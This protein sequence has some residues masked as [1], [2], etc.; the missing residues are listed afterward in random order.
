MDRQHIPGL[1]LAVLTNGVLAKAQGYGWAD[2]EAKLPVTTNTLFQIQSVTKIFTATAIMLLA[3][4]GKIDIEKRIATYLSNL[5]ASWSNVT[6]RHLL[7]HTS[8]IKDFINEPTVN[9]TNDVTPDEIVKSLADLPLNF[10]TGEQYRYSNTGYQ[11]LGMMIHQITGMPWHEFVRQ[12]VLVPAG[13]SA[14]RV[15][16]VDIQCSDLARGYRWEK[17]Q[18][19]PGYPVAMSILS[20]PGGGL[21]SSAVDLAAWDKALYGEAVVKRSLLER[22]WTPARLNSGAT[23]E[24]GLGW[25]VQEHLGRRFVGHGGAHMTGFKAS[26]THFVEEKVTVI[27]LCN[28]RGANPANVAL[29]VADHYIPGL[30]LSSMQ[31]Q[32]DPEPSRSKRLHGLLT[33]LSEGKLPSALT[34]QFREAYGKQS[35]RAKTLAT[36]LKEA[37]GFVYLGSDDVGGRKMERYGAPVRTLCYYKMPLKSGDRYYT[38]YLTAEGKVASYQSSDF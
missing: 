4:E 5:P 21:L 31:Q 1:A 2:A 8:G 10:A 20:Y 30:L 35:G 32:T 11:L 24:Y 36:R 28:Q 38:F 26:F 16:A 37:D 34:P 33:T 19:L 25:G 13:M 29:R 27:V 12:R 14:T 22:M 3:E 9:L 23:V 18:Q 17:D 15:N 7:T 6:V